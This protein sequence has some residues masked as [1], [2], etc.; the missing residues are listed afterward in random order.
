MQ[1][2]FNSN[3]IE[4]DK[5]PKANFTGTYTGDVDMQNGAVSNVQVKG[6]FTLHGV[7][8]QIELPATLQLLNGVL[9][10]HAVFKARPEDYDIKIPLLVKD[11]ISKEVEVDVKVNCNPKN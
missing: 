8:K 1:T 4:S 5:Y 6:L 10:G 7:S 2:H 3:Y 9:I 11:N